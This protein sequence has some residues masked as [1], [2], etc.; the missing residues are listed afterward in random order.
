[1]GKINSKAKGNANENECVKILNERFGE[2]KFKRSPSSGA[3]VGGQNRER[4]E[5]LSEEAKVTLASDIITPTNFRFIIEH[6]AYKDVS[7]WDLFNESSNFFKWFE[8][9]Q[10]DA[11]F[12]KRE[13]ILIVKFNRKSRIAFIKKDIY[14]DNCKYYFEVRGWYCYMLSDLLIMDDWFWYKDAKEINDGTK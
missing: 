4:S 11:I 10:G 1:M 5:N 12:A 7:F 2:G 13:P 9:V 6:K 14:T 8:Q 3:F